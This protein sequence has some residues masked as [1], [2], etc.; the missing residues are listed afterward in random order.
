LQN[1]IYFFQLYVDS[2]QFINLV[3]KLIN[4][5]EKLFL[6]KNMM[7]FFY[8]DI[9]RKILFLSY[10]ICAILGLNVVMDFFKTIKRSNSNLLSAVIVSYIVLHSYI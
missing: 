3:M 10:I 2:D 5:L 1:L 4:I 8:F 9:K 6:T 7:T